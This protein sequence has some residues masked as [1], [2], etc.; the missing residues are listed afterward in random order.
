[1]K[2]YNMLN[3]FK[4][5]Y[6]S[7]KDNKSEDNKS[8]DNE[9]T[10]RLD[11]NIDTSN[12]IN[13]LLKYTEY[14]PY[15]KEVKDI[16]YNVY[17]TIHKINKYNY[18]KKLEQYTNYYI[19]PL[20]NVLKE[21]KIKFELNNNEINN[22]IKAQIQNRKTFENKINKKIN[23]HELSIPFMEFLI[24]N[25]IKP[26]YKNYNNNFTKLT[27]IAINHN[28]TI[29]E[30]KNIINNE[31]PFFYT[32]EFL[33]LLKDNSYIYNTIN[34]YKNYNINILYQ[35]GN[36]FVLI[37]TFLLTVKILSDDEYKKLTSFTSN[38][39]SEYKNKILK[40]NKR[41]ST[42]KNELKTKFTNADIHYIKNTLDMMKSDKILEF[43]DDELTTAID[44]LKIINEI[45]KLDLP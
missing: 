15:I 45:D 38:K 27:D 40:I 42:L 41:V 19:I 6:K 44:E 9:A 25:T 12:N 24:L 2:G 8:E 10:K 37:D 32:E 33:K 29:E 39:I 18:T 30:N 22:K 1:M 28:L 11:I 26:T 3:F 14:H 21:L 43:N 5:K 4:R 23:L 35:I 31:S 20:L 16:Y 17:E 7:A 13:E 36:K 34:V